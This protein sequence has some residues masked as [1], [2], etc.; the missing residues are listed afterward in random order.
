MYW[1]LGSV[2]CDD[3]IKGAGQVFSAAVDGLLGCYGGNSWKSIFAENFT[4]VLVH[5]CDAWGRESEEFGGRIEMY[6][7]SRL[8]VFPA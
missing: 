4:Y 8:Q 1:S 5:S 7:P 6:Y 2:Y 3:I